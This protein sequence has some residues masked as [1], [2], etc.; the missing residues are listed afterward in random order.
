MEAALIV[1]A[2]LTV[3]ATFIYLFRAQHLEAAK[4]TRLLD[5]IGE[6]NAQA[7]DERREMVNRLQHPDRMPTRPT[8]GS[9]VTSNLSPGTRQEL[10]Q[11]GTVAPQVVSD[12]D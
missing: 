3:A 7:Q 1:L 6:Q 10:W 12:G 4:T 5:L 8:G 2:F 11:V 9:R